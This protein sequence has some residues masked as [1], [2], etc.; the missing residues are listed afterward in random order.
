L[1]NLRAKGIFEIQNTY[2][3]L[4]LITEE[5]DMKHEDKIKFM[6]EW[7][8]KQNL[9]LVLEGEV[10]FGRQCVGVLSEQCGAYPDYIIFDEDYNIVDGNEVWTPEDAYHKHPCVAVLGVLIRHCHPS[11]PLL[12]K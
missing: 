9:T 11:T 10:G 5:I 12:K 4:R 3:N 2:P 1:T 8:Q 6:Q 7:C